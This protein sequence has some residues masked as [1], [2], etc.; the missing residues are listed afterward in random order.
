MGL[1]VVVAIAVAAAALVPRPDVA[2]QGAQYVAPGCE[3]SS[4]SQTVAATFTLVNR[5]AADATVRVNF[6]VDGSSI[7]SEV[8]GVLAHATT[9]GRIVATLDDCAVHRYGLEYAYDNPAPG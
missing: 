6:L 9:P 8:F 3:P 4:T 2:L 7:S 1:G 5:G